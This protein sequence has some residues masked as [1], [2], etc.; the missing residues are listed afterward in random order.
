MAATTRATTGASNVATSTGE[1]SGTADAVAVKEP[2]AVEKLRAKWPWLDHVMHMNERYGEQ[3]GNY[4]SAGITYFSVLSVFPLVMLVVAVVAM[5][6]AGNED[7]L[8]D[9]IDSI[10]DSVSGDLGD[11]LTDILNTAI[12]QRGS[13]F[14]I[15][16]VL[17]L[18]TGLGWIG[19]L[20]AGI[21]A[22]WKAQLTA[23]SF[24]KGKISDLIA[25]IG[26]L[27][28]LIVAFAVTAIGS[29]GFTWTIIE[30]L[31]MDDI[32]GIRV[33]VWLIALLIALAANWVVMFWMLMFFPRTHVPRKA[34]VR[35][36]L[37]GAVG[38]EFFKQFATVF[39]NNTMSNPAGAAFGPVIGVMVLLYLLWRITLYC[40]AWVATTPEAL[41]EMIP[42]AP[43]PAII[44][45]RRDANPRA[46]AEK[47]TGQNVR[48]A[49]LVGA[50]A[51]LGVLLGGIVMKTGSAVG[52]LFRKN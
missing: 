34:A 36:A 3:G 46:R 43:A 1:D 51:A 48:K 10:K 17:T 38:L 29:G 13:I 20:R 24:L 6:L 15:G 47:T 26:L 41:A 28:S 14:G 44:Q 16:L 50:G 40:S 32:G 8:N 19:N 22:M 18:W 35:G 31:N 23:D 30:T 52:G 25:L 9:I 49:G 39:F 11:T 7:L 27:V 42:D 2:T 45:I 5:V 4:Y 37:I 21:S 33:V 12:G